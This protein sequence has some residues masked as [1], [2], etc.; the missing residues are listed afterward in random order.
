MCL[1]SG[2][3]PSGVRLLSPPSGVCITRTASTP[4]RT[5]CLPPNAPGLVRFSEMAVARRPVGCNVLAGWESSTTP[6]RT[7]CLESRAALLSLPLRW[8]A[9][10]TRRAI[11]GMVCLPPPGVA[12][13]KHVIVAQTTQPCCGSTVD[14]SVVRAASQPALRPPP[15]ESASVHTMCGEPARPHLPLGFTKILSPGCLHDQPRTRRG[16]HPSRVRVAC[17]HCQHRTAGHLSPPTRLVASTLP[18]ASGPRV[19]LVAPASPPGPGAQP[20]RRR[21]PPAPL[22]DDLVTR[23]GSPRHARPHRPRFS[24]EAWWRLSISSI[25]LLGTPPMHSTAP[26][27]GGQ[28]RMAAPYGDL[29]K[30]A[31]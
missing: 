15:P 2:R 24:F 7:L 6:A 19:S 29:A 5:A 28:S 23:A 25:T 13:S 12:P 11:R 1:R 26:P 8:L 20:L 9:F 22:R 4:V 27:G 16:C 17:C 21:R 3:P 14:G 30:R 18:G 10:T 31:Q